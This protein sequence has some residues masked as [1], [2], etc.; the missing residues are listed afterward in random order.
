M[1]PAPLSETLEG[2]EG[3]DFYG[4]KKFGIWKLP[5]KPEALMAVEPQPQQQSHGGVG[6]AD[7]GAADGNSSAGGST[8]TG[9]GVEPGSE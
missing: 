7:G 9:A 4:S 8:A 5:I 2:F 6:A 1:L 3:V